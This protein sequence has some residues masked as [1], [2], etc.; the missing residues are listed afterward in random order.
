MRR[1]RTPRGRGSFRLSLQRLAVATQYP[2]FR[3]CYRLLYALAIALCTRRLRRI[4]GVRAIYLRRGLASGRPVYGLSDIDLMVMVEG[5][6]TGK[7]AARVRHQYDLLR[8]VIPMLPEPGELGL[9]NREHF[10]LLY[11]RSA[12]YRGRFDQGRRTWRRLWGEEVFGD[13]PPPR[14]DARDTAWQELRPAWNCL[15]LELT[16]DPST[17][18]DGSARPSSA[19]RYVAYKAIAEA[20]RACLVAQGEDAALSRDDAVVRAAERFP[21]LAAH[22]AGVR[23]LRAKLSRPDLP[24]PD[25]L[26]HTF[27]A[28]AGKTLASTP[29]AA[30]GTRRLRILAPPSDDLLLAQEELSRLER[31]CAELPGIDHIVL[32]PR[33]SF[34]AVPTLDLDPIARVGATTDAFD[35]VLLGRALPPVAE[36]QRLNHQLATLPPLLRPYFCDG[37]IVVATRPG[38]GQILMDR[39][40]APEVFAA[41]DAARPLRGRLEIAGAVVVDRTFAEGEPFGLRARM[42]LDL[43]AKSEA[44]QLPASGFLALFWEASRAFVLARRSDDE[45]CEVPVTSAQIVEALARHTPAQADALRLLHAEYRKA[46]CGVPAEAERYLA[47]AGRYALLLREHLRTPDGVTVQ[48]PENPRTCL[49]IS[50]NIITRNRAAQLGRLLASLVEQDR[51]PDQVVVV[52]NASTDGTGAVAS[53]FAGRLPLT[54]VREERVGIP[55][56]RNTA[57]EHSTGSIV[58]LIDDDCVA[59]RRWLAEIEKPFVRDPH[60]GAVGGLVTPL[61]ARRGLV[62]RFYEER[63]GAPPG[64]EAGAR[65]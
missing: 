55:F 50:V 39:R 26:M 35:V 38:R 13:L 54:L 17:H 42:L 53:S 49:A 12:F 2:P 14:G 34:D 3:W 18:A 9:Y 23:R 43:F 21:E 27:L 47:W 22:L 19:R 45:E 8:R 6:L 15:A 20:A 28:L 30:A 32:L 41:L 57:L 16:A 36:L 10:Q 51:A 40:Q 1:T 33:L 11:R 31:A 44:F 4:P 60:V 25:A 48:L 63:M 29:D 58:A 59:D 37:Q 56:A 24:D 65:P 5:D 46:A 64:A 61:V 62:A 52:D 7:A